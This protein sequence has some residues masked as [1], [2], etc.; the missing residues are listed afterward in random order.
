MGCSV[1]YANVD[2]LAAFSYNKRESF[3]VVKLV[4]SIFTYNSQLDIPIY[5]QL[6]DQIRAAVKKGTLLPGQQLPTVQEMAK[7]LS[8]AKGTIKRAYDELEHQGLL[9]KIQGRGTFVC[10]RPS[11]SSSRK[12]RAMAAIDALLSEL[13]EMGFSQTE[14]SIFL[15]LK[16]RERSEKLSTVKVAVVECSP[17]A[18][19][20][21]S[22]QLRQM[23]G[24]ELYSYL[25]ESVEA[26]P[27]KLDED[28]EL[29]VTT[30]KHSD[31]IENILPDRR[32][33]AKVALRLSLETL[34][35]IVRL[36]AGERVGVICSSQRFAEL[37]S[38]SCLCYNKGVTLLP[39]RQFSVS[40]DVETYL[41]EADALLVP[42]DYEKYCN[43]TE[44]AIL[45]RTEKKG[46]LVRCS[47]EMDEGSYLH[48]EE[49][50]LQLQ[51]KKVQ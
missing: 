19:S 28:M 14:I 16:Q 43:P 34:S 51:Q 48:L 5:Q 25:L 23:K 24:I 29:V 12:E 37:V 30:A 10:Y 36:Q 45:Q 47:Y 40:N 20:Q 11:N 2:K 7:E 39:P 17:E 44:L 27:Y 46:K 38:D 4:K 33:L 31:V 21:M 18:L 13:E 15:A 1:F 41:Q 3:V 9:E 6:V 42:Y 22:E 26:Y 32:K 50:L 8:I 49:K 35:G